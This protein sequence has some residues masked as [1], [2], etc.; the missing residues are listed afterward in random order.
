M[1]ICTKLYTICY[2]GIDFIN[3]TIKWWKVLA[4]IYKNINIV[5]RRLVSK[6]HLY[7]LIIC[8]AS[9]YSNP[10]LRFCENNKNSGLFTLEKDSEFL[11]L[12]SSSTIPI[13]VINMIYANDMYFDSK[14]IVLYLAMLV[15]QEIRVSE[16]Y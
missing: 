9:F 5:R 15:L 16:K 8:H 2:M 3:F 7:S 14:T 12:W 4:R 1:Y 11:S 6:Q 13:F 10:N